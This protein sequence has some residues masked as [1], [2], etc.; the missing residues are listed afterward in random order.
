MSNSRRALN[1]FTVI[2]SMVVMLTTFSE[3][4]QASE[5]AEFTNADLEAAVKKGSLG[6]IRPSF[7]WITL[8]G[9]D[10]QRTQ[11]LRDADGN[12]IAKV[13]KKFLK[14]LRMEG[15]GRLLDGRVVNFKSRWRRRDGKREYRWQVCGPD[16]PYGLGRDNLP[17]V[18]FR[19]VAVDPRLIPLWSRLYIPAAKGAVLPSGKRHDGIF[20][21]VDIGDMIK[22]KKIDIFTSFGDQ[23]RVFA[24]VGMQTGKLIE[25]F[26]LKRG[27][28]LAQ[29]ADPEIEKIPNEAANE[30]DDQTDD[31]TGENSLD[32]EQTEQLDWYQEPLEQ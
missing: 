24:A 15:T 7:Y 6:R 17:L 1:L 25:V 16:A 23:S 22:H 9:R 32:L 29:D 8:E 5:V 19:S 10:G 20:T 2:F 4:A 28:L 27:Q 3:K 18:P 26:M 13:S 30:T 12:L 21:A 14:T 11:A 31:E